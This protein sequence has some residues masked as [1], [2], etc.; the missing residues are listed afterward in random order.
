MRIKRILFAFFLWSSFYTAT[1]QVPS[2]VPTNGL[3]GYWPF[4]GNANDVS[5]NAK[6]GTVTG[7]TLTS[8]R[9]GSANSAYNFS[10]V[11]QFIT[12]PSISELNG[13]S[14]ASFSLW[15]KINGHNFF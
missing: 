9:F 4:S 6:N 14:S 11:T 1:A 12:C 15:V 13:S 10:G 3:V 7:A 2:N 5:G 8:D